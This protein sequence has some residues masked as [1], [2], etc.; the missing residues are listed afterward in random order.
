MKNYV[1]E[2]HNMPKSTTW[3]AAAYGNGIYVAVGDGGVVVSSDGANWKM[4]VDIN[5]E[6]AGPNHYWSVAYGNGRFVSIKQTGEVYVSTDGKNWTKSNGGAGSYYVTYG[7]GKFVSGSGSISEDGLTWSGSWHKPWTDWEDTAPHSIENSIGVCY[8][9]GKF[10]SMT[11]HGTIFTRSCNEVDWRVT[12]AASDWEGAESF[13]PPTVVY[14]NGLFFACN[15]HQVQMSRDGETWEEVLKLEAPKAIYNV[16]GMDGCYF[17]YTSGAMMESEDGVTWKNSGAAKFSVSCQG[18][19]GFIGLYGDKCYS[20]MFQEYIPDAVTLVDGG[21][22]PGDLRY[23]AAAGW[24]SAQ[25]GQVFGKL[26]TATFGF[27]DIESCVPKNEKY[28]YCDGKDDYLKIQA[29]IDEVE[30]TSIPTVIYPVGK[31][32]LEVAARGLGIGANDH[33]FLINLGDNK[34][35]DGRYCQII[36]DFKKPYEGSEDQDEEYKFVTVFKA[37]TNSGVVNSQITSQGS[38]VCSHVLFSSGNTYTGTTY[39]A[40]FANNYVHDVTP[41]TPSS[42]R[43][44]GYIYTFDGYIYNNKFKS[45]D[46]E[47]YM[48]SNFISTGGYVAGNSFEDLKCGNAL[49][50]S[51]GKKI[52]NNTFTNIQGPYNYL[53]QISGIQGMIVSENTFHMVTVM[54][55]YSLIGMESGYGNIINNTFT[56]LEAANAN[57]NIIAIGAYSANIV[58]SG[59]NIR[60]ATTEPTKSCTKTPVIADG[61]RCIVTNNSTSHTSIGEV[62]GEGSIEDNNVVAGAANKINDNPPNAKYVYCNGNDDHLKIQA[63]IDAV[64]D[65]GIPTVIYPVGECVL[66]ITGFNEPPN[67]YEMAYMVDLKNNVTI[68]GRY[69][70]IVLDTTKTCEV[71]RYI[72]AFKA[73]NDSGLVN[74]QICGRGENT[75]QYILFTSGTANTGGVTYRT[76][77]ANNKISDIKVQLSTH[78]YVRGY[79]Y[80]YDGVIEGNEFWNIEIKGGNLINSDCDIIRNKFHDCTFGNYF[81]ETNGRHFMNNVFERVTSSN[82]TGNV[83]KVYSG[84]GHV[85]TGNHFEDV[86]L[87]RGSILYIDSYGGSVR[88]NLVANS[89]TAETNINTMR[90]IRIEGEGTVVSGNAV[91][92]FKDGDVEC[93]IYPYVVNGLSS[94]VTDNMTNCTSIGTIGGEGTVQSNNVATGETAI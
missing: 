85:V 81:I 64:E 7:N 44:Y 59:N 68:D 15:C 5:V 38:H 69:C 51:R 46:M 70:K 72:V 4:T 52:V 92:L 29:A 56:Q 74:C 6:Q 87:V 86:T 77:F 34:M 94:I 37:G 67:E 63:A 31:C 60:F 54:S 71:D 58:V 40:V 93:T 61:V 84:T 79:I 1:L 28:V 45:I 2:E 33:V 42:V 3:R 10:V 73:G 17:A 13:A 22:A 8:G 12:Y 76:V 90:I 62:S 30:D 43:V 91:L 26:D 35:L 66:D 75:R 41:K 53:I 16:M 9:N 14:R 89:I 57:D 32:V 36:L 27:R 18:P 88:D 23:M 20:M 25:V 65:T 50:Q 39:G 19:N 24:D 83:I 21:E 82:M 78:Y 11:L 80:V 49:I 55:D 47:L 48:G